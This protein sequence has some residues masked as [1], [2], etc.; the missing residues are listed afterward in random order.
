MRVSRNE[1]EGRVHNTAP[2]NLPTYSQQ[3]G[4][5]AVLAAVTAPILMQNAEFSTLSS[6]LQDLPQ[7]GSVHFHHTA[8]PHFVPLSCSCT[9]Q[10][11]QPRSCSPQWEP[12]DAAS[13]PGRQL[14]SWGWLED[15]ILPSG[16]LT[17]GCL[18]LLCSHCG[19][20]ASNSAKCIS[21]C[22]TWRAG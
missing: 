19:F 7:R 13:L 12:A 5:Q 20:R 3:K 18:C 17:S 11:A 22:L 16:K 6:F 9:P 8:E 14:V 10:R 2:R 1:R 15:T 21:T 4:P